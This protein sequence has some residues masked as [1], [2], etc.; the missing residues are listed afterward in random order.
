[1]QPPSAEESPPP[2]PGGPSV[3]SRFALLGGANLLAAGLGFAATLVVARRFGAEGLGLASL[4][5]SIFGFGA[6]ASLFGT[7]LLAVRQVAARPGTLWPTLRAVTRVRAVMAGLSYP[8]LVAVASLVPGFRDAAPLVALYGLSAFAIALSAEWVPQALHRTGVTALAN[9]ALQALSLGFVLLGAVALGAPLW[10]V[11]AAKVAA[12]LLVALA[13][14]LWANRLPEPLPA[15][16][17]APMDVPGAWDVARAAWPIC[18]TQLVRTVAISSDLLLL[19]LLVPA[20]ALGHYAAAFRLYMVL[21]MLATAYFVILLPRISEAAARPAPALA[22]E[23][24][25]SLR[26]TLPLALL[27][28]VALAALSPLVMRLMFGAG[29]TDAAPALAIL[30][31]ATAASL[32]GRHWRQVLLARGRQVDDLRLTV[33][34]SA[35]HVAAKLALIPLLGITGAALGTLVGEAFILVVQR[36]AA[37]VELAR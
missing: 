13:L 10:S 3:M 20:A 24:R 7:D 2:P 37:L 33:A 26:R 21:M 29:F 35:V 34:G 17:D 19:A 15:P 5:L 12:D 32:V 11:A 25:A 36:R 9:L 31:A 28:V 1:M 18:A 8:A 27:G 6:A 14:R 4:A 30:G 22:G 16:A 23:M